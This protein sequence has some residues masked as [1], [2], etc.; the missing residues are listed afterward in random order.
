MKLWPVLIPIG[1]QLTK[2]QNKLFGFL[3][4]YRTRVNSVRRLGFIEMVWRFAYLNHSTS[5]LCRHSF[6]KFGILNFFHRSRLAD[7]ITCIIKRLSGTSTRYINIFHSISIIFCHLLFS[8]SH[9]VSVT[10]CK[11]SNAVDVCC[12][13]MHPVHFTFKFNRWSYCVCVCVAPCTLTLITRLRIHNEL[14][15]V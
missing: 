10:Q 15:F 9:P 5:S 12:L 8:V 4:I 1:Q 2:P 3:F 14:L 13:S 6:V 11:K 7:I